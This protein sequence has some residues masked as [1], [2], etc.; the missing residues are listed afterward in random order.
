MRAAAPPDWVLRH[1]A[2]VERLAVAMAKAAKNNGHAVDLDLVRSGAILHDIGRSITQDPHHAHLGAEL[3]RGEGVDARIVAIVERHTGAGVQPTEAPILGVPTKDYTPQTLEE[4]IVAHA[5]N[6]YSGDRRLTLDD[7][8]AKYLAKG[9]PEA[10]ARI[11]TLHQTL[12][13]ICGVDLESLE[14]SSPTDA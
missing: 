4:R 10:F 6:L 1:V 2:C 8:R 12:C 9:L 13:E 3:L 5:D 7:V 11:E 14:L